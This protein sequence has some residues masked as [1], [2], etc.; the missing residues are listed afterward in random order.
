MYN[1]LILLQNTV[2]MYTHVLQNP[3][4]K[5]VGYRGKV[6]DRFGSMGSFKDGLKAKTM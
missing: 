6:R 4:Q 2:D 1:A 5:L 3:P